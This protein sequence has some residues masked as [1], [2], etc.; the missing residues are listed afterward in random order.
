MLAYSKKTFN[1]KIIQNFVQ[2]RIK[3]TKI[4]DF[5]QNFQKVALNCKMFL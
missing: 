3:C 5:K 2:I 1:K 4:T